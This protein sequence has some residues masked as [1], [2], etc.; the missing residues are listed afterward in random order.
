LE[1]AALPA[2]STLI[3]ALDQDLVRLYPGMPVNGIDVAGFEADG[4]VFALGY[5]DDE[6]AV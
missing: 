4:G 3:A 2:A 1:R 6:L 5:V